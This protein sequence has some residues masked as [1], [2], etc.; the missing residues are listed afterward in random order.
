M[1]TKSLHYKIPFEAPFDQHNWFETFIGSF[2]VRLLETGHCQSY[3]F[4]RYEDSQ[5]GRHARFRIRT[6]NPAAIEAKAK[7]FAKELNL[8]DL[9]D[10]P[11]YDGGEIRNELRFLGVNQRQSDRDARYELIWDFLHAS[12][13]L[14]VDCL[15]HQD[16]QG[17]W[18]M[19]GNT[20][21]GNCAD[22]IRLSHFITFSVI[23][24]VWN[25]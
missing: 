15:S 23:L 19:E 25:L 22:G 11:N 12:S 24:L 17:R 1:I 21:A 6:E 13:K 7:D 9:A 10:E 5:H 16:E 18:A 4:S 8:N 20:D 3:W 14:F 2:V